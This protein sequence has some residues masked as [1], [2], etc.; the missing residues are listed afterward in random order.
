MEMFRKEEV[1]RLLA[2]YPRDIAY[3]SGLHYGASRY[4]TGEPY[5]IGRYTDEFGAVWEVLEDGVAG[6][7]KDPILKTP[8]DLDQYRLPWEL[9]DEAVYADQTSAYKATDKYVLGGTFVRP[10]E[11]MQF[12]LGTEE[13]F[14]QIATEDPMFLRLRDMLH[15]FNL[16]NV[17]LVASLAVDGVQFMDDWG[18]QRALLISPDAWRKYYKPMY[19]EYCEIIHSKGKHVFFHSD[20]YTEA[21]IGDL[22]EIGVDALNTQLFCMDIEKLAETHGGKIAFWGEMDRQYILPFGTPEEVRQSVRRLGNALL[23]EKRTGLIAQFSWET[24]TPFENAA[25]AF[26]EFSRL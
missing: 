1:D 13:L 22:I 11:R 10:F 14:V 26:E 16:K 24:V 23:K 3:P 18:S 9:L 20:G 5:R 7:V 19:K 25:A 15:E 6:E 21:I 17:Q 2:M 4:C 12:L 8:G